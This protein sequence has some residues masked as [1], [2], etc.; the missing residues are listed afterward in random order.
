MVGEDFGRRVS[1][2]IHERPRWIAIK[3]KRKHRTKSRA[4]T[5]NVRQ[6]M[7]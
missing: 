3:S 6:K 5:E 2:S 7:Q 4:I 1:G